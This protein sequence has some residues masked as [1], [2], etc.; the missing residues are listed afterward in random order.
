MKITVQTRKCLTNMNLH[1]SNSN[2]VVFQKYQYF[3]ICNFSYMIYKKKE[4]MRYNLRYN[5]P[6]V[7]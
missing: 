1:L 3:I 6:I 7:K 5:C 2:T 4:M